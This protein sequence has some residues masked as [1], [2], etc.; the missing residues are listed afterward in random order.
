M[1]KLRKR[2]VCGLAYGLAGLPIAIVGG[3]WV[4]FALQMG[5]CVVFSVVLGVF[6]PLPAAQ[7]EGLIGLFSV[8]LVPFYV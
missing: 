6:N 5:L 3:N 8:A 2:A 4:L 1:E 7:E